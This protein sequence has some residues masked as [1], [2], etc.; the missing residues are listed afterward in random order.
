MTLRARALPLAFTLLGLFLLVVIHVK[1]V[2]NVKAEDSL[3]AFTYQLRD[4]QFDQA[5]KGIEAALKRSPNNAH[6]LS[7]AGLLHERMLQRSFDFEAL[8]NPDFSETDAAHLKTAIQFYQRALEL[9]PH[10]DHAAHNLGWLSWLL[11]QRP[12]AFS[13]LQRAT[14]INGGLPLYRISLG[15]LHEYSG[16]L[17]AAYQEYG[18][19]IR[20]SPGVAD[21]Q[22]FIDFR[23]RSPEAAEKIISDAISDFQE[24]VRRGAGPTA[25][26][27]LGKLTLDRQPDLALRVWNREPRNFPTSHALGSISARSTSA[28]GTA[29]KPSSITKKRSSSTAAKPASSSVWPTTTIKSNVRRMRSPSTAARCRVG[30]IKL[31]CMRVVCGVFISRVRQF[32]TT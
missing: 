17:D 16:E 20:I 28:V 27:K 6:F 29:I 11:N 8:R 30:S 3:R 18:R 24:Q 12:Q 9:N 14:E 2:R 26:A 19:A 5:Q 1:Y 10:D 13:Y 32:A 25:K 4:K 15:V 7:N 31:R 22:F 21:S 23:K